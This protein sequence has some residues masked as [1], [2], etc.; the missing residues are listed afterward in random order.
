MKFGCQH[1]LPRLASALPI[2]RDPLAMSVL[3][4][5]IIHIDGKRQHHFDTVIASRLH[6]Y[7]SLTWRAKRH[8]YQ[9]MVYTDGTWNAPLHLSICHRS[10]SIF[11]SCLSSKKIERKMILFLYTWRKKIKA[12]YSFHAIDSNVEIHSSRDFFSGGKYLSE[13]SET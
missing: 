2:L 1:W 9:N 5:I 3:Q 8:N 7:S 6:F 4:R 10:M 12:K 11:T 13:K